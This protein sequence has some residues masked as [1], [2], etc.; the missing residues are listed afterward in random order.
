MKR[1]IIWRSNLDA[2]KSRKEGRKISRGIAIKDLKLK[3]ISKAA[4]ELKLN[5]EIQ[6]N[7]IHPMGIKGRIMVDK[8]YPKIKTLKMIADEIRKMRKE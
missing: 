3:E 8:K 1:M 7:K 4:H 6:E 5:P 2:T